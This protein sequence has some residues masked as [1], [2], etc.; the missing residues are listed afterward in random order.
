MEEQQQYRLNLVKNEVT[1]QMFDFVNNL[2]SSADIRQNTDL[3]NSIILMVKGI[4]HFIGLD[5]TVCESVAKVR[6]DVDSCKKTR[7]SL[8]ILYLL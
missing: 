8:I 6:S 7:L 4:S 2:S 3:R 5:S 1:E